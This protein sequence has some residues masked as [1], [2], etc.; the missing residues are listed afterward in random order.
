V[1]RRF[2]SCALLVCLV[3]II[4][5]CTTETEAPSSAAND[6]ALP[7]GFR[8]ASGTT[9]VGAPI[10]SLVGSRVGLNGDENSRRWYAIL[11]SSRPVGP[12]W[13]AYAGQATGQL[14][15]LRASAQECGGDRQ[16]RMCTGF[17]HSLDNT[18]GYLV[19][20]STCGARGSTRST[21]YI[22]YSD[23][24]SPLSVVPLPTIARTKRTIRATNWY[25][26]D[27]ARPIVPAMKAK[28]WGA[29]ALAVTG[30]PKTV[31]QTVLRELAGRGNV[32]Q[33]KASFNGARVL[34]A[35]TDADTDEQFESVTLVQGPGLRQPV[36]FVLPPG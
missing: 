19:G 28:C 27:G 8:V 9:V 7:D 16:H 17:T 4:S 36:L 33:A 1:Q 10:P 6:V 35:S 30:P 15:A 11:T 20:A 34:Q 12:T 22:A 2:G 23:S 32:L 3:L 5:S 24:T 25:T 21:A 14:P 31:W 13:D 29:I 26:I 18:L